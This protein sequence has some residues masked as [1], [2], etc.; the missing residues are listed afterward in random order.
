MWWAQ[1]W[2]RKIQSRTQG[3]LAHIAPRGCAWSVT[4]ASGVLGRPYLLKHRN[5]SLTMHSSSCDR[6]RL[7]N[8]KYK[9]A[10]PPQLWRC[11]RVE[12]E[13]QLLKPHAEAH[14]PQRKSA[15][16]DCVSAQP[17]HKEFAGELFGKGLLQSTAADIRGLRLLRK[18]SPDAVASVAFAT[19]VGDATAPQT[20]TLCPSI[21]DAIVH[22]CET[23]SPT[24]RVGLWHRPGPGAAMRQT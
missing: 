4:F 3:E 24:T 14:Y 12:R 18:I 10:W 19:A 13:V 11:A 21:M 5:S 2:D 1:N 15:C 6:L 7:V 16:K 8:E 17:G 22:V 9:N 23:A 20:P